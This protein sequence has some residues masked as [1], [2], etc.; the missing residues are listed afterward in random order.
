MSDVPI[1]S[2]HKKDNVIIVEKYPGY[3]EYAIRAKETGHAQGGVSFSMPN[4]EYLHCDFQ[5]NVQDAKSYSSLKMVIHSA[6]EEL[7]KHGT[8]QARKKI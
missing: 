3:N 2:A 8:S 5:V 1:L 4:G 7:L 6:V